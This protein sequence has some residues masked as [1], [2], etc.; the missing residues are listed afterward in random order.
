MCF[1]PR[2]WL[3]DRK[4]GQWM[5]E[6]GSQSWDAFGRMG[7]ESAWESESMNTLEYLLSSIH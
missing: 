2:P 1:L 3:D 4:L 7:T 5:G 6:A